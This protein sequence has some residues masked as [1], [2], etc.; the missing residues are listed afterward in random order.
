MLALVVPVVLLLA[1]VSEGM[2]KR[3]EVKTRGAE[4]CESQW[5]NQAC[6]GQFGNQDCH[7][8][9]SRIEWLQGQGW[10]SESA[11]QRVGDEF[12]G[13]CGACRGSV[14]DGVLDPDDMLTLV[15]QD[16]FNGS[17]KK[18]VDPNKW[19]IS[20]D[21]GLWDSGNNEQQH[22]TKRLDNVW[23]S[24]GTLKLRAVAETPLYN[25]HPYTSGKI[26][27]LTTWKYGRF[28]IRSRIR[29]PVVRGS[30]AALWMLPESFKT[31]RNWPDCGEIDIMEHVGY[32]G[33]EKVHGTIHTGAYNHM[34]G[35][36]KGNTVLGEVTEWHT[37]TV[38]W[39]EDIMLWAMDGA[40]YGVFRND[41][42]DDH[43]KWPFNKDFFLILN[44]AV[45]GNWGAIQGIDRAGFT[46]EGHI[47]EVDWVRVWERK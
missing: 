16:E 31:N 35:T 7:S 33:T 17:G 6:T 13:E 21:A 28:S 23:V 40:V 4:T 5:G 41:G 27:S 47:F 30:W 3:R 12:V 19:R 22:Y 2:R 11:R 37:W 42:S 24:N 1:P 9:G 32:E 10:S 20:E 44:N 8:C 43:M 39:R 46:G 14:G 45:G 36:Q 34:K 38:E 15:W 25:H 26:E 18:S 29:A